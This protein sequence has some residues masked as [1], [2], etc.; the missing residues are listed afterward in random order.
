MRTYLF[1]I[2]LLLLC[3]CSKETATPV[4]TVPVPP[5]T[6]PENLFMKY[7]I[8]KGA[9][10]SDKTGIKPFTGTSMRLKVIFDSSAIYK[11]RDASNQADINKL[12]GFTEG[13][14]NHVHSAR[15]GW[16]WSNNALRLYAYS[17]AAGRRS[18][19]EISTVSIGQP[20]SLCLSIDGN[21]YVFK[22]DEKLVRLPRSPGT[23]SVDGYWQY[24]YFGGDEEAPHDIFIY[25]Q[26]L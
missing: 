18:S 22:V 5:D 11:T 4:Q 19:K 20:V 3:S 8:A 21:E 9:H 17:Y 24:P 7:S 1:I 10:Y 13:A 23:E 6:V 26:F 25:L 2:A 15:F 16:G 12:V 14:D